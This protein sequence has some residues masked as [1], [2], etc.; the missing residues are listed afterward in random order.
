MNLPE[1]LK[2][3]KLFKRKGWLEWCLVMRSPDGYNIHWATG[4]SATMRLGR[5]SVDDITAVDWEVQEP[6][7][8]ITREQFYEAY[9]WAKDDFL[10]MAQSFGH[11]VMYP[12]GAH[13]DIV[14]RIARKLG[15]E[16]TTQ[17]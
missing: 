5:L 2:S 8:T 16:S 14:P 4:A 3:G 9:E 13:W 17:P 6:T 11:L 7:V 10:A 1:V 12:S 15:L